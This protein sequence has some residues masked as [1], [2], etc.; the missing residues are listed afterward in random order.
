MASAIAA[1]N[2]LQLLTLPSAQEV[3]S[4]FSQFNNNYNRLINKLFDVRKYERW[5]PSHTPIDVGAFV[6]IDHVEN[7]DE[8]AQTLT[9]HGTLVMT[10]KDKRLVWEP[11]DYGNLNQTY[12]SLNI[13]SIWTPPVYFR[14]LVRATSKVLQYHN[15][16]ISLDSSGSI[17]AITG[18]S[19]MTECKMD[20]TNY[21][22]DNQTCSILFVSPMMNSQR[23]VF[24]ES[25]V[26]VK[27]D[28][29]YG[30]QENNM[31]SGAYFEVTGL[32]SQ[33]YY[34]SPKGLTSNETIYR[35]YSPERTSTILRF[36]LSL[37]R[38]PNYYMALI[39]LPLLASS[40]SAY[41]VACMSHS[42]VSLV[43]LSV[44]LVMQALNIVRM[45]EDLPPDYNKTPFLW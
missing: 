6:I 37:K 4:D 11:Q 45:V 25:P 40:L 24:T 14:T 23:M 35:A 2:I 13:A 34:Y 10:W 19:V 7:M 15:T 3:N 39:A 5:K 17:T 26:F 43:W 29:L 16:E 32:K 44:C 36:E 31:T 8:Y 28:S 38:N 18:I 30:A 41:V 33:R 27:R 21:P 20:Y 12:I 9:F 22:F 42:A 1:F